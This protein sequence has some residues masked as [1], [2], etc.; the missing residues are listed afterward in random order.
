[1]TQTKPKYVL[2]QEA[3]AAAVA[4]HPGTFGLR[5]FPGERFRVCPR[6][7]YWSE[8]NGGGVL[9]YTQKLRGTDWVDFAKG[10]EAILT[11]EKTK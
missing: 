6:A 3:V 8:T 11:A 7:S 9:L 2:E 5:A 10:T 1:M 4:R